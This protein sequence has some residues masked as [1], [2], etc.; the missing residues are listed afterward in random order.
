MSCGI[1][2]DEKKIEI[3]KFLHLNEINTAIVKSLN[4][5]SYY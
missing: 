4:L 3:S 1:L 2:K 5:D